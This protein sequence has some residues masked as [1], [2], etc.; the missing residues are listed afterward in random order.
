LKKKIHDPR[1]SRESRSRQFLCV[2]SFVSLW[3]FYDC[4]HYCYWVLVRDVILDCKYSFY[5]SYYLNILQIWGSKAVNDLWIPKKQRICCIFPISHCLYSSICW[6]I[7]L[8]GS[9]FSEP[10]NLCFPSS[11]FHLSSYNLVFCWESFVPSMSRMFVTSLPIGVAYWST[12]RIPL[13]FF[14]HIVDPS[15]QN[16]SYILHSDGCW[17]YTLPVKVWISVLKGGN[18]PTRQISKSVTTT[19]N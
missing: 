15:I 18:L 13:S 11:F 4:K 2:C 19:R 1:E 9:L 14:I 12:I 8:R 6:F 3:E 17:D 5:I 7:T 10:Y 16:Q